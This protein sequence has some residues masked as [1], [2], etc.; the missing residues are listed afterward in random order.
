MPA[1]E[2]LSSFYHLFIKVGKLN[3]ETSSKFCF[4]KLFKKEHHREV[5]LKNFHLNGHTLRFHP[6][7]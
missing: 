2:L 7:T 4:V 3:I 1:N 5:L 6:Q